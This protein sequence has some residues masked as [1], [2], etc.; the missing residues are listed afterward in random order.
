MEPSP[1]L[2]PTSRLLLN[3]LHYE[4]LPSQ[5]HQILAA[6][7]TSEEASGTVVDLDTGVAAAD[8][9]NHNILEVGVHH[10]SG[11]ASDH[12][13]VE[14]GEVGTE[15]AAAGIV[16]REASV[17]EM[18]L[19]GSGLGLAGHYEQEPAV[20]SRV[21]P[22]AAAAA[23]VVEL[24]VAAELQPPVVAVVAVAVELA[25]AD[26]AAVGS[27][28]LVAVSSSYHRLHQQ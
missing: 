17:V 14:E 12:P 23:A 3:V 20:D 5:A 22:A 10:S 7:A 13:A 2:L 1:S 19:V 26:V 6:V 21:E 8:Q 25:V 16:V 11:V 15:A 27:A 28:G 4:V 9:D 18:A 24:V